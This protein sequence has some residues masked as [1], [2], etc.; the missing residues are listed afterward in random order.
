VSRN[1]VL[2]VL[3]TVR[4]DYFDE[5]APRLREAAD[6]SFEGC[7]T[8]S[9]WSVPSHTSIFTG[10]LPH[11]HGI[12]AE[13]FDASFDFGETLDRE[14]TVLGDLAEYR[15]VG[16]SANA[17]VNTVFGIDA[18]FD[19]FHDFSIGSHTNESLFPD[20]LTVQDYMAAAEA[21]SSLRR[22]LGFLRAAAEHEK[23]GRSLANG[24][25][26]QV[27]HR[28]KDLPVPEFVDDGANAI[29]EALVEAVEDSDD[30]PVFAFANYMDAHTPLRNLVQYD[31]D[32][33]SVPNTWSSTALN[34][35]E[36]NREDAATPTYAENYR[37]LYGAA[38]DYLDRQVLETVERLRATTD[39]ETTV[40]VTAD[41]GHNLGFE[42]ENGLYHHTGSQSE[43]L[44][45]VPLEIIN[46]PT[47]WPSTERDLLSQVELRE[48][49]GRLARGKPFDPDLTD[50]HAAAETVGLLGTDDGTWG[51]EFSEAEYAH[52]SRMIRTVYDGP[53]SKYERDSEGTR[54]RHRLDPERPCWQE[55]AETDV[56][57]PAFAREL[58]D[59]DLETYKRRAAGEA[60]DMEFDDEVE[61]RLQTLGYL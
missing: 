26:S 43:A 42:A 30:G 48:I 15:T 10:D 9:S 45:H 44:L 2:V 33:H 7:R 6:C 29:S 47:G 20:G 58:F 14:D 34:K 25:W 18:L 57:L 17:Y 46:P 37:Q 40:V 38:V 35:W 50:D 11:R 22:H 49:V 52:W 51:L 27:G 21:D 59:V 39:R 24:V 56:E 23:P 31:D 16:L 8:A 60:Q 1:V 41:H 12:H 19:E 54:E 53:E 13:S 32:L 55:V 28:F 5:Y 61:D 3:D 36:L 4:K